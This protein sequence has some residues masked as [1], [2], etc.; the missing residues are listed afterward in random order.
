MR[1]A[2]LAFVH[3][4]MRVVREF[5]DEE[6]FVT[7]NFT[8]WL[9]ALARVAKARARVRKVAR[10]HGICAVVLVHTQISYLRFL[11]PYREIYE[12]IEET[13]RG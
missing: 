2:R 7:L 5:A 9:E 13:A 11:H 6:K 10:R 4:Q 3:G 1:E 8:D 12:R